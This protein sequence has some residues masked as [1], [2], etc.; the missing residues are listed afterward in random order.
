[1]STAVQ[2]VPEEEATDEWLDRVYAAMMLAS[3]LRTCEALLLGEKVPVENLDIY[4]YR[5]LRAW[6]K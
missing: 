2:A 4:W 6:A 1:M 5:R 3:D